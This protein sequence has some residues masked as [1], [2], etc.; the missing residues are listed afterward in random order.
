MNLQ[1]IEKIFLLGKSR[2]FDKKEFLTQLN[3]HNIELQESYSDDVD[4][5]VEGRMMT[6][7]EQNLSDELYEKFGVMSVTIDTLERELA[8]HIDPNPLL[9]SLKLSNDKERLLV[10][11][12]NTMFDDAL[13]LRLVKLYK[14]GGE[15]FFESDENRDVS[16]TFIARF[17]ENIERNHNI[18]YATTGFIHLIA[19]TK[20][21]ELLS[22]I[23][24]LSPTKNHPKMLQALAMNPY[25]DEVLQKRLYKTED[26]QILQ[27]LSQNQQLS[28]KIVE[29]LSTTPHYLVNMAQMLVL[30]EQKLELLSK[31]KT[32]LALNATLPLTKQ[33]EFVALGQKDINLALAKNSNLA[34]EV[35]FELLKSDDN[36]LLEELYKNSALGEEFVTK[37]Y[38][39]GEFLA[40]IAQN[41]ATPIEILYQLQLDSRYERYVRTNEKFGRHIQSEN[42]GWLV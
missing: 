3:H 15:D 38:E 36:E 9:M 35:A 23:Y 8:K 26:E 21:S 40:S 20:S 10:F 28:L 4:V 30:D 11:I 7:Y 17:Y 25:I 27:A 29:K 42:I 33:K 31:S 13:F 22:A 5:V 32:A 6:P 37:A 24:E 34:Q 16:S 41:E 19:Q 1:N 12:Q 39:K 14:W 2:A 18:Q